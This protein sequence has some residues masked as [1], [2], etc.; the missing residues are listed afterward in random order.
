M[1]Q[2]DLSKLRDEVDR[3]EAAV[4][5]RREKLEQ[6]QH[7]VSERTAELERLEAAIAEAET[8]LRSHDVRVKEQLENVLNVGSN[9]ITAVNSYIPRCEEQIREAVE[10]IAEK[11]SEGRRLKAELQARMNEIS[12]VLEETARISAA[13]N[14]YSDANRRVVRSVPAVINITKEKLSRIENQLQ[15]IDGE[16]KQALEQHQSARHVTEVARV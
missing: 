12:E 1:S 11:V 9:L 13:L 2:I 6:L 14:L 8:T 10:T 5:P 4:G 7:S 15:D 3:L 16:L